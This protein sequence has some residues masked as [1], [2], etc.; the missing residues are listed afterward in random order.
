MGFSHDPSDYIKGLQ[1]LLNNDKKKIGFLFGAG[2]SLASKNDRSR[3]IP[4]VKEMT[5][6]VLDEINDETF[7]LAIENIT[8]EIVAEEHSFN[9]ESFLTKLEQKHEVIGTGT[10]NG[11]NRSGFESLIIK[12]KDEICK[13]VS[14][15]EDVEAIEQVQTDFAEW[16]SIA[17]RKYPV[18][19]FTTNYDYL[20]EIGL[21][22]HNLPY[23]DGFVG[24]YKP[25]FCSDFVS[26]FQYLP[27]Q[28]KLWKLHGSLGLSY[29]I[30]SKKFIR[31]SG[32]DD[33]LLIYPSV[34]KY[35][36]SKKQP[37][38]TLIDR[39]YSF[40]KQEDSVL[41]TC[42]YSFGDEHVNE[43]IISGLQYSDGA[44]LIALLYDEE[45]NEE[46]DVAKLALNNNKISIYSNRSAVIGCRFGKWK[47]LKEPDH[48]K[49]L[50]LNVYF[51]EDAPILSDT[52]NTEMKGNEVWSGE[53]ELTIVDFSKLIL[54]LKNMTLAHYNSKRDDI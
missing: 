54:F 38:G 39:L 10:L 34:L 35:T 48:N 20:F 4:A 14:I 42:G 37:Y 40:M 7:K 28:T 3:T 19:I 51:D 50:A 30:D 36:N 27:K 6:T 29:D 8:E 47:L 15:H 1:S 41:I 24:S 18:E 11:L 43:R 5:A 9:I 25:F 16:L 31:T 23:F 12:T 26:D 21:E 46:S 52:L 49:T 2:S 44:N 32:I 13:I 22:Y 45:F 33:G 53:G 17:D